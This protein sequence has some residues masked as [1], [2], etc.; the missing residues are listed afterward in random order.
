MPKLAS[1]HSTWGKMRK[2]WEIRERQDNKAVNSIV[3]S[4]NVHEFI[5]EMLLNITIAHTF[6]SL[7]RISIE[8]CEVM[9]RHEWT[10]LPKPNDLNASIQHMHRGK[11]KSLVVIEASLCVVALAPKQPL[12]HTRTN[13]HTHISWTYCIWSL[14]THNRFKQNFC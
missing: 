9:H 6:I 12:F 13:K 1:R 5:W 7:K 8:R 4:T 2:L 14:E 3:I 11:Y 10:V